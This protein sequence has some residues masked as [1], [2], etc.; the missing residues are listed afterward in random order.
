MVFDS[1]PCVVQTAK[2][3]SFTIDRERWVLL[4][5]DPH[6]CLS[7]SCHHGDLLRHGQAESDRDGSVIPLAHDLHTGPLLS[8]HIESQVDLRS[9]FSHVIA[10]TAHRCER[11]V[12]SSPSCTPPLFCKQP[13]DAQIKVI[14]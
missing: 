6:S 12:R 3:P 9:L 10:E 5:V 14:C 7:V 13:N 8:L 2:Q 1:P 11:I 4:V